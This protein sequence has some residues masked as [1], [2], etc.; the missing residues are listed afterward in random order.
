MDK[1]IELIANNIKRLRE[2][3]G[4]TQEELAETVNLSVSHISKVESGQ[5]KIGMK[6]YLNILKALDANETDILFPVA[7]E[8][9]ETFLQY[10]SIMTDC[11][12]A[13]RDFLLDT[14]KD[15]KKNL[16]FLKDKCS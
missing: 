11:S 14:L 7:D 2:R 12:E 16:K 15:I 6:A 4:Y 13:E 8:D 3:K 5:R 1:D 9:S 10:Q